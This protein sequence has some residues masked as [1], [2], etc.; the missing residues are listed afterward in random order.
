MFGETWGRSTELSLG[1]SEVAK[2]S[3]ELNWLRIKS[4][5]IYNF[6]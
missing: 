3:F 2:M 1:K 4:S 6:C 5:D